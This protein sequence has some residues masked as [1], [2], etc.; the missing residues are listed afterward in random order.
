MSRIQTPLVA[1]LF[2]V[3]ATSSA[4]SYWDQPVDVRFSGSE[5]RDTIGQYA[6]I[7]GIGFLLD[8]RVDPGIPLEFT[9]KDVS[10]TEM[11][12]LLAKKLDLGFCRIGE[13]AY[14]GPKDAAA[15]LE[16]LLLGKRRIYKSPPA[17]LRP[18]VQKIRLHTERL[19]TPGE[20]L[21]GIAKKVR[22]EIAPGKVIP[23]DLWPEL[24][25]PETTAYELLTL[26]LI[27]FDA[28]FEIRDQKIVFVPIPENLPLAVK[29]NSEPKA[30]S[31]KTTTKNVPLSDQRFQMVEVKNKTL[32]EFLQYL[33][34]SLELQV[35]IDKKAFREKGID[36]EQRISF[37]LNQADIHEI[38]RAALDP[39][40]GTYQ[41][42]GKKL[43]I[44]PKKK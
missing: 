1:L 23:H 25:F 37:Q 28:T 9:A 2:V 39:V 21:Q 29:K 16:T 11:F 26:L 8:R 27:G 13:I 5:L 30:G 3:F 43:R 32:T 38:L 12:Q 19:D 35:E 33:S 20:I 7:Q 17:A 4:L 31:T 24:D 36:P 40:G 18:L 10:G 22:F 6:K 34:E 41:L 15:K 42:S 14:L 44:F